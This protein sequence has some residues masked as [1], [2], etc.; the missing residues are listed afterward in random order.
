MDKK[1]IIDKLSRGEIERQWQ[2]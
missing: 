2:N 1:F